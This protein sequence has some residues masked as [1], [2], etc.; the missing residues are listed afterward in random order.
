MSLRGKKLVE[1]FYRLFSNEPKEATALL[2]PEVTLDWYSSTG[3]R[4]LNKT[5]LTDLIKEMNVSY[6][7]L[8]LETY[9][10]IKEDQNVVLGVQ[11]G[12]K[13]RFY[14]SGRYS[15]KYEKG[16]HHFHLLLDK[17]LI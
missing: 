2:H 16:I 8:R 12:I 5:N 17:Y 6:E 3:Y 1:E 13:S 10:T 4:K 7:S 14:S 15:P 9:K 11:K